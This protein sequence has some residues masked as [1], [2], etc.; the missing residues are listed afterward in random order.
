VLSARKIPSDTTY[1]LHGAYSMS[2]PSIY[3]TV[4]ADT[5]NTR[6][7]FFTLKYIDVQNVQHKEFTV[8]FHN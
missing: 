1:R 4:S 5:F 2:K 7:V 6:F 8:E 3:G